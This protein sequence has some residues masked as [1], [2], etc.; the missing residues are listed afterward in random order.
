M[1]QLYFSTLHIFVRTKKAFIGGVGDNS[2]GIRLYVRFPSVRLKYL[3]WVRLIDWLT[4]C[5]INLRI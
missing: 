1:A 2:N 5:E 3:F 4:D